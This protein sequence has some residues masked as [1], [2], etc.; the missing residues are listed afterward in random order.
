MNT[1]TTFNRHNTAGPFSLCEQGRVTID[2]EVGLVIHVRNG[3]LWVPHEHAQCSVGV[4]AAQRFVVR[5][6]GG[7][8]AHGERAT[9]LELEWPLRADTTPRTPRRGQMAAAMAA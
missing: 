6:A 3:C 4:A 9:E 1:P 2:A 5:S 8:N 7:M